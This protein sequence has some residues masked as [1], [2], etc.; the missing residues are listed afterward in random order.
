MLVELLLQFGLFGDEG[1]EV[2]VGFGELGVDLIEAGEHFDDG[3]D[4]LFDDFD[5]GLAFVEFGLLLE[6]ARGVAFGLRDLAD[7]VVIN[8]CHDAQ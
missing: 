3:R 2:G 7:V 1:V 8:A 5:D 6:Q 4:R